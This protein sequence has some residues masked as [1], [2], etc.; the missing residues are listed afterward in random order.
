MGRCVMWSIIVGD[1]SVF[2]CTS[3]SRYN[4][5]SNISAEVSEG[6]GGGGGGG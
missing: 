1:F 5:K 2:L 4:R 6:G 3:E